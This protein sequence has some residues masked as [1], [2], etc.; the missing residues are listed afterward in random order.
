DD[1]AVVDE[2]AV[3]QREIG[4]GERT[5]NDVGGAWLRDGSARQQ[6]ET[7]SSAGGDEAAPIHR[8]VAAC[9]RRHSSRRTRAS[10]LARPARSRQSVLLVQDTVERVR[11]FG[12]RA[13]AAAGH[14]SEP[15]RGSRPRM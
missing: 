9:I 2:A 1:P 8:V 4:G 15:K 7:Q 14:Y 12:N 11:R 10:F 3:D 6:V 13:A 5:R